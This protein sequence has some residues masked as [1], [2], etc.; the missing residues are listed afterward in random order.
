[1]KRI[2][3]KRYLPAIIALCVLFGTVACIH[4]TGGSITPWERVHTYNAA[5]AEANNVTEQGAEAIVTSGFSTA[6]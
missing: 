3:E 1:M 6:Q 4:K 5:L 2:T